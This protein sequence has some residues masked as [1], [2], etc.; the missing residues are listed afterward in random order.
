MTLA[1]QSLIKLEIDYTPDHP[2]YQNAKKSG[3]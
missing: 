2:I 3:G 1:E